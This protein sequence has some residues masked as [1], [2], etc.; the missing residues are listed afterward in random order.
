MTSSD[1]SKSQL[2][3]VQY[4]NIRKR[5][6]KKKVESN[7][8]AS[9]HNVIMLLRP[10]WQIRIA[11]Q[12]NRFRAVTQIVFGAIQP[13]LFFLH[14]APRASN[15]PQLLKL[16]KMLSLSPSLHVQIAAAESRHRLF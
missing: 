10:A 7:L 13:Y 9:A 3:V 1:D 5:Y 11:L 8:P 6:K 2:V 16:W 12:F 15:L 14:A 4:Y